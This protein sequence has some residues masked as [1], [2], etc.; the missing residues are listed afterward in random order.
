MPHRSRS[1]RLG[2]AM[3]ARLFGPGS[4]RAPAGGPD[5]QA[6]IRAAIRRRRRTLGLTQ[7]DAADRLGLHRV[8]LT[9]IERGPR[10]IRLAELA[11]ICDKFNCDIGELIQDAQLAAAARALLT[12]ARS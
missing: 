10:R 9:R 4:G 1:T 2:A 5:V 8:T 12:E 6:S 11:R 7:Q 3:T